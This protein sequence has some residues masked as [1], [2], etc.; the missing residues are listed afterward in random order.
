MSATTADGALRALTDRLGGRIAYGG[1]YNPEQWPRET[2]REDARLMQEAGVNLVTVG[3][4]SWA[5]VEPA[6]G[7]W[8]FSGLDEVLDLLH[9]HGIAVDLA[10]AT[11]SPPP[12]FATRH[13]EAMPVTAEGVR[14]SHGSRQGFCPSSPVYA[15]AAAR[16][17]ERIAERYRDHPAVVLW[18]VHNEWGN[19]NA[20]C[21]CDTSAEAFRD[22]LRERY[23]TLDGLNHA[24]GTAFWSQRYGAWEEVLPPRATPAIGNPTQQLDHWRFSSDA[25][26]A[27]HRREVEVLRR[28]SPDTPLTTNLMGT[29][30]K[31]VDG[32]AFARETDFVSVDHYLTAADPEGHIGLS[33][34]AD[35]ARGMGGGA[36]WLLME[37]STSAVNWQPRNIAKT[38]GQMRRNSLAHL[39]RG[40]DG[41]MYFQWRQSRAG[42]EKWH[43]AML[44]HGGTDTKTW[45]ET[46]AL[47]A[48][49][50]ALAEVRGTRVRADVALLFDW[51]AWWAL[52]LD[53]RPSVDVRYLDLVRAWYAALWSSGTACD[54][55]H[56]GADLSGYRLVLVPSQ[57]LV[58]DAHAEA[59]E[60][61]VAG[62]GHAA[63][64]FFSGLVDVHDH[65]RPGGYPGAYREMLGLRTDEFH[66][67][68]AG[69]SVRLDDGS[70][71]TVWTEAVELRGAEQVLA[72]AKGEEGGPVPGGPAVT[73]HA[74]G[75]G[76]AWYVA[77]RPDRDGL[78]RILRRICGEAGV[79]PVAEVPEGVEAVRRTGPGAGYLFLI[80][81]TGADARVPAR[82][83]DVVRGTPVDGTAVV[84]AGDVLVVRE[85]PAA[86]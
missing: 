21:F 54:I 57:Y 49:L 86:G 63:V 71:A 80:N 11:A 70:A 73:R 50:Q 44:P 28:L 26:L 39:A 47:G 45:R 72:F 20:H 33:F 40:A 35:L 41:I 62:G 29:L 23:G 37:H 58:A 59:L 52:E 64:G 68:R 7:E 38:P 42:A 69:E 67:L 51:E 9:A 74:H 83:I 12:W 2:W 18:H 82:G 84:P 10:T 78:A 6:P 14:L 17:V 4:F 56:P 65:V 48:E 16:L 19:H 61:Y 5:W 30:E 27:C 60:R 53:A 32:F 36:P 77:T 75:D 34:D 81:H 79:A 24:W 43:S 1:D 66:P 8:D 55:V 13:P 15:E 85:D 46:A 3:V 31:K 76:T 22:W 25:L